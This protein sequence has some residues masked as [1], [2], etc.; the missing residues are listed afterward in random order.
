SPQIALSS[1]SFVISFCGLCSRN[2]RTRKALGSMLNTLPAFVSE[3]S[4]SR[5]STSSKRK[6]RGLLDS[7]TESRYAN[8]LSIVGRRDEAVSHMRRALALD[9]LS[10]FNVR[11]MG[12]VLY[13]S[14]RY[15]ESL[16]YIRK[17]EEMEPELVNVT[18]DWE[19]DDYEMKGMPEQAVM[20]DLR[21]FSLSD[22]KRWH[23]RL[24]AAY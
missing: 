19:V 12:S 10:F 22:G 14:R 5:T 24:N 16:E 17:A 21:N 7:T 11:L 18:V 9:P 8:F 23:D 4:R 2:M 6:T 3:N 13:W 15:D 1:S 20:A